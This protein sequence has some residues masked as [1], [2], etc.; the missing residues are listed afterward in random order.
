MANQLPPKQGA[1]PHSAI[2]GARMSRLDDGMISRAAGFVRRMIGLGA[3]AERMRQ[4]EIA[5][6]VEPSIGASGAP[7]GFRSAVGPQGQEAARPVAPSEVVRPAISPANSQDGWFGP[8][9]AMQPVVPRTDVAGRQ[10]DFPAGYNLTTTP[11]RFE[12][13]SFDTLRGLASYDLVRL[14]IETRKDQLARVKWTILPKR[15][16]GQ[17]H[18][19]KAD[20]T[21]RDLEKFWRRPDGVHNWTEWVRAIAE[22]VLVLDAVALYRRRRLDRSPYALDYVDPA[23]INLLIDQTGRRPLPP[24]P[25]YQQILKGLP[26]VEFTA[27]ELTY[28]VRNPRSNRVYGLSP[29]EQ[30]LTYVNIGMRRMAGQL[31]H[32]CYSD[33]T[34]VLT[35]RGWLF[36]G[37]VTMNDE[38]ASREIGTGKFVWQKPYDY[39]RQPYA[40]KMIRFSGRSLDL[41]VTPNHRM[42]VNSL[43]QGVKNPEMSVGGEHVI[44]AAQMMAHGTRNTGIPQTSVWEGTE[45]SDQ[46]FADTDPR[47][48]TVIMSGDDYCAFMGMY[49]AEGNLNKVGSICISQPKDLRGAHDLYRDLLERVF[50]TGVTFCGHQFEVCRKSLASHLRQFG[51]AGDKFIPREIL[52]ATPRQLEIF[53][54]YYYLG[55]GAA[56]GDSG[57]RGRQVFTV[58]RQLADHLT[59]VVQKLGMCATVWTRPAGKFRVGDREVVGREGY[60]LSISARKA[61]KGW[62]AEEVDYDGIVSCVAVPSKFLYVRRNGKCAWSGNTE[63]NIP[64]ALLSTPDGWTMEQISMFQEYWDRVMENPAQRRRAKFV[65]PGTNYRPTHGEG[66]A[67]LLD[68]FDEWLARIVAYAFSLPPTPFVRQMNRATSESAYRTALEEGLEPMLDW[69]KNLVDEE[70]A[71][72]CGEPD[73]EIVWDDIRKL[74]PAEKHT[75]DHADM[76]RGLKSMDEVRAERGDEPVGLETHIVWGVGPLG[77]MSVQ[78]IKKVIEQGL[79]MP[80]P[81]MP[82]DGMGMPPGADPLAGADPGLLAQLGLGPEAQEAGGAPPPSV[83]PAPRGTPVGGA[84][85]G[86]EALGLGETVAAVQPASS[87]SF[88]AMLSRLPAHPRASATVRSF[89]RRISGGR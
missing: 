45:I 41:F 43:P 60:M 78:S 69:L 52:D 83:L 42:L 29:V 16:P 56:L 17:V 79:D 30:C 53:W 54:R 13:I 36:F 22:D 65:P 35:R 1:N 82:M 23:T 34:E 66:G 15:P 18:K 89:E 3:E 10:F 47:S 80:S 33:D 5:R 64:E 46:V 63:G 20:D 51:K 72:F 31:S 81:Q 21:C 11:R 67:Q 74:D 55:D 12:G 2:P 48:T 73:Y 4:A 62:V 68:Q 27:E 77:F 39:Y 44:S 70:I 84:E 76:Q 85:E 19:N 87:V 26:A 8:G 38:F 49:L 28:S 24:N 6:R 50:G 7:S 32:Y 88:A 86:G 58:S 37:D 59:E 9:Q 40:G 14:A 61:T 75:M 25:A 71:H 57:V